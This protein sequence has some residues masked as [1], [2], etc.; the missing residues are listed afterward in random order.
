[1]GDTLTVVSLTSLVRRLQWFLL[2]VRH[3]TAAAPPALLLEGMEKREP[4]PARSVVLPHSHQGV[5]TE[6]PRIEVAAVAGSPGLRVD[7][8]LFSYRKAN[9]RRHLTQ[10]PQFTWHKGRPIKSRLSDIPKNSLSCK[11]IL[12]GD[13]S[14][15]R[16]AEGQ[17]RRQIGV[18]P[19]GS[20]S[21][22]RETAGKRVA[23]APGA[24]S[25]RSG[26]RAC[27]STG[28][29]PRE[30]G[31]KDRKEPTVRGRGKSVL[32]QAARRGRLPG[33]DDS[34]PAVSSAGGGHTHPPIVGRAVPPSPVSSA[35]L[36]LGPGAG[37][38]IS[39]RARQLRVRPSS[40]EAL[41]CGPR[42]ARREQRGPERRT[43]SLGARARPRSRPRLAPVRPQSAVDRL[44]D[45]PKA[46]RKRGPSSSSREGGCAVL[47][48]VLCA[49]V[50][51]D[52]RSLD[53]TV[54]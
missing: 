33:R 12:R 41:P 47:A 30:R 18:R 51:Y 45:R 38:G 21:H 46:H 6:T 22:W 17:Q 34:F 39:A 24:T 13:V 36:P 4:R 23:P 14:Q 5:P 52:R 40:R 3:H 8:S 44:P 27:E 32:C 43:R 48:A 54:G 53:L 15:M 37:S 50:K 35:S 11:L 2:W 28:L 49:A 20:G 7:Q 10:G 9:R 25:S 16:K 19:S 31:S 29:Q 1:M 42:G 26:G